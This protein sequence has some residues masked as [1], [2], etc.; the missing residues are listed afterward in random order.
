MALA[1]WGGVQFPFVGLCAAAGL[2]VNAIAH[3][4]EGIVFQEY[5]PGLMTAVVLFIPL[6][7]FYFKTAIPTLQEPQSGTKMVALGIAQSYTSRV[8]LA[9]SLVWAVL[10]HVL[11]GSLAIGIYVYHLLPQPFYLILLVVWSLVPLL[12]FHRQQGEEI[13]VN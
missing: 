6:S 7:L 9:T 3:I 5:N 10:A 2:L 4:A 13:V 12:G 11:L 8:M 1:V